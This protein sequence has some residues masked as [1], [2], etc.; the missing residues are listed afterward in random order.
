MLRTTTASITALR[1]RHAGLASAAGV[2]AIIVFAALSVSADAAQFQNSTNGQIVFTRTDGGDDDIFVMGNDGSNPTNL[3]PGNAG[4]DAQ[5]SVSPNGQTIVFDRPPDIFSM[6]ITGANPTNLTNGQGGFQPTF[7][8]DGTKIVFSRVDP[9]AGDSDVFIMNADGS[10][11]VNLTGG[12]PSQDQN[13]N[14]SPDGTRLAFQ[15]ERDGGDTD[16]FTMNIN[17]SNPVN[18]TPANATNDGNP[19]FSPNG[20]QIAFQRN[21]GG[22]DTDIFVM[23]ADGSGQTNL[24]TADPLFEAHPAF[25]PDG[26]KISFTRDL[27]VQL[28]VFTMN[29]D[30]SGATN[31]TVANVTNDREAEWQPIPPGGLACIVPDV[32]GLKKGK[33]KQAIIDAGCTVG[34]TKKKKSKKVKK[35]KVIKTKPP[36]GTELP[37]GSPVDLKVSKGKG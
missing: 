10:N 7:T 15:S 32:V 27:G 30:G 28:D 18:L 1:R 19:S 31:L 26:T 37:A 14:V 36:A 24:T 23:N 33:A 29:P 4:P 12:S 11:A 22:G 5:P 3:T 20:Q 35:K 16:V 2:L 21:L 9:P 17:G 34:S 25:S 13:P 6:S 8:P